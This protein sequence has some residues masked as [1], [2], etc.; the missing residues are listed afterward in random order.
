MH[1]RADGSSTVYP[2]TEA[3]A[4][5]FGRT[6]P[7]ARVTVG[8]S[9]TGGGFK[10]LCAGETDV[11]DASR[12]ITSSEMELC[13][14]SGID[15]IEVPIAYDGIVVVVHPNN[16]WATSITTAELARLWA[17]E[18][19][20]KVT[21]WSQ[22]REG[23]P[24]REIHLYGAGVASG[25]YDYFTEAIL[26]REHASRGDYTSSED[27]NLLVQGVAG[28]EL[29]LA[30]FGIAY[31]EANRSKLRA[32]GVDDGRPGNG[33]GPIAPSTESVQRGTYQPLS[34]P[35]FLY[36]ARAALDRPTVASFV[37]RCLDTSPRL[38][39]EVGF[40][41]LPERAYAFGAARIEARRTGTIFTGT[42][43][44][45]GLPI[46]ELLAREQ[47]HSGS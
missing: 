37:Q 42:S 23:W 38:A 35:V 4:E 46:E 39:R 9:G 20:G 10:K 12:P 28:D 17:P 34:R 25:T 47:A 30:F 1:V 16:T 6:N 15:F 8:I 3:A 18:A 36:V 40:V 2:L 31:Y 41:P 45:V 29:A 5:E 22:V 33:E 19:Q 14:K 24:D 11:H 43:S 7:N 32:L 26:H 21:R 13:Q 44:A 27:D